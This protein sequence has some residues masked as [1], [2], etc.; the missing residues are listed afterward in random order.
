MK[1][2]TSILF[3]ALMVIG[4]VV[5]FA[6]KDKLNCFVTSY[7]LKNSDVILNQSDSLIFFNQFNN[8]NNVKPFDISLIELG[9]YGCK[10]CMRMDTV[11]AEIKLIFKEKININ[12]IRVTEDRGKKAAKYF[13]VNAIP[14][15]II[16][17]K[18][19][20]EIYRHTGYISTKELQKI[21]NKNM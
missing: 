17:D 11:L 5:L 12:T 20:S 21:I 10:P 18:N 9:G 14:T 16:L 1:Q 2:Y 7:K 6:F 8:I 13:G 19:S 4:F 15:Q 3:I